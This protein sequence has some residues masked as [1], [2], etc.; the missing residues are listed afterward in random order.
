MTALPL[1]KF[2]CAVGCLVQRPQRDNMAL[3]K[4]PLFLHLSGRSEIHWAM[5]RLFVER[6]YLLSS[7]LRLLEEGPLKRP[8]VA[9]QASKPGSLLGFLAVLRSAV[10]QSTHGPTL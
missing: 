2:G 5:Y 9:Q 4:S 6:Y 7:T 10:I 8:V 1:A 3:Q